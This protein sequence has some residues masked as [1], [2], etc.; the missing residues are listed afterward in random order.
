M[1]KGRAKPGEEGLRSTVPLRRAGAPPPPE[2][3]EETQNFRLNDSPM[4][5]GCAVRMYGSK[6]QVPGVHSA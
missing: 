3:G 1:G 6:P 4:V 5:R 2:T